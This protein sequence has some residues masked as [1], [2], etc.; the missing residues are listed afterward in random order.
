LAITEISSLAWFPDSQHLVYIS[1]DRTRQHI[2]GLTLGI[3]DE[4]WI[5][6]IGTGQQYQVGTT[7]QMLH[8]IN[9]SPGSHYVATP[10]GS[11]YFDPCVVDMDLL[12]VQ[13]D[14]R[15]NQTATYTLHNFKGLPL[16]MSGGFAT[17]PVSAADLP[18]SG[19]WQNDTQLTIG[20][21]W[22]C[23]DGKPEGI[24]V[25]DLVTLEAKK[26]RELKPD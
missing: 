19:I 25:L 23:T 9:I 7:G 1:R 20:L 2:G 6:D 3:Q 12:V 15:L 26:I 4:M 10:I 21:Q 22:T 24:Y 11:G 8:E 17:Y 18:E 5:V 13:L 14:E 16:D